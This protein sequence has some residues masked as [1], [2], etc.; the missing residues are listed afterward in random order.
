VGGLI[1]GLPRNI[2]PYEDGFGNKITV[3]AVANP[4]DIDRTP[5]R[6]Y[7]KAPGY[8]IIV[9]H[10]D[11]RKID[12]AVWPRWAGPQR[13][14]PDNEPFPGWPITID[15]LDNYGAE[16]A[17]YLPEVT[18]PEGAYLQVVKEDSGELVYAFR[19]PGETFR[20]KVFD[21]TA[22]YTVRI[23]E[24]DGSVEEQTGLAVE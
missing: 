21:G 10:K 5:D 24:V 12:L 6:L 16:I 23:I 22:T 1:E 19:P 7:D 14:A 20:A 3:R 11:T 4:H 17:G 2:G 15:Q 18:V 8:S 9:F 13:S